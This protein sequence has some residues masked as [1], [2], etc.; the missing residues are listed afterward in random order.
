VTHGSRNKNFSAPD[1][2]DVLDKEINLWLQPL[3][4]KARTAANEKKPTI[5]IVFVSDSC[6]SGTVAR[7][8]DED[9]V[10]SVREVKPDPVPYPQILPAESSS[11]LPGVRI[12]AARD[13]ESAIELDP[14]NGE[15]C[16]D[17]K[18][19]S[20]VFTWHWVN[21]LRQAKPGERWGDVF[22]RTFTMVTA[23]RYSAQ[24]PQQEG[25]SERPIFEGEFSTQREVFGVL[26]EPPG[27]S[28]F[29]QFVI[30]AS[31]IRQNYV[32]QCPPESVSAFLL[33]DDYSPECLIG[34]KL[35]GSLPKACLFSGQSMLVGVRPRLCHRA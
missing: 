10:T 25:H 6:H 21:A 12:G 20:G 23:D 14:R 17:V 29:Q 30:Q 11:S 9:G 19:C 4:K 3:Y 1:N 31:T 22:K 8:I 26:S 15:A 16:K 24:R 13:T 5:D 33:H 35:L 7:R 27:I 28:G 18:H 2:R 32:C 34:S